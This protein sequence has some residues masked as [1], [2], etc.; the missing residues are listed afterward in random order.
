MQKTLSGLLK[1]MY[2]HGQVT[3]NQLEDLLLLAIEGRQRVRNQLHLM[4]PGEYGPVK[5]AARMLASGKVVMP[6][7][8][9]A[10]ASNG[11]ICPA[12][13]WWAR[14]SAWRSQANKG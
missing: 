3:D 10:T 1:L 11:W 8:A 6:V 9:E 13:R 4:A 5:I 14:S 7:L 2:P 12:S